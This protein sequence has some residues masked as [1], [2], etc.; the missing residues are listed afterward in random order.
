MAHWH[1]VRKGE[2]LPSIAERYGFADW[3]TI[4]ENA[5]NGDFRQKRTDPYV[6]APGDQIFI[7]DK[8]QKY[9]KVAT[10]Q[11]HRFQLKRQM[12]QVRLVLEDEE[13]TAFADMAYQ[14]KVGD[15]VF[16]GKT[17]R[18]GVLEAEV[19]AIADEGELT[20]WVDAENSY[21]WM[22]EIGHLDPI[23][24][25]PGVQARLNNLGFDCGES[26]Q[27]DEATKE[28]LA[29][30]QEAQGLEATGEPDEATQSKLLEAHGS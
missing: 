7:P 3:K 2:S 14:L 13:G 5:K 19:P 24:T 16:E 10:E 12:A 6:L 15:E 8:E 18:A 11:L 25:I 27:L 22:I 9:V 20:L 29:A 28:A 17:D 26:G 30:F 21:T 1:T 4:Y 23:D